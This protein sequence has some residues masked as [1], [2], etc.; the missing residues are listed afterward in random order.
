MAEST[1]FKKLNYKDRPAMLA[2]MRVSRSAYCLWSF[3]YLR[4]EWQ[5]ASKLNIFCVAEKFIVRDTGLSKNVVRE[6]KALLIAHG[7]ITHIG[8]RAMTGCWDTNEYLVQVGTAPTVAQKSGA[9][10]KADHRSPKS[11][12]PTGARKVGSTVDV[13]TSGTPLG[14]GESSGG[15]ESRAGGC[16]GSPPTGLGF[17]RSEG[18]GGDRHARDANADALPSRSIDR[19]LENQKRK[20]NPMGAAPPN[21][22]CGDM[23]VSGFKDEEFDSIPDALNPDPVSE[24][25]PEPELDD[26]PEFTEA[27][28]LATY[29]WFFLLGRKSLGEKITIL[30]KWEQYWSTD[31][32]SLLDQ[33]A[34]R[35]DIELA[36][37]VSQ[38]PASREFY[39]RSKSIVDQF[40]LLTEKGQSLENQKQDHQCAYC[41]S[42]F[43]LGSEL[44][45]HAEV[46]TE[47]PG[48][49]P[50]DIAEEEAMYAAEDPDPYMQGAV[51]DPDPGF[52]PF[53]DS[54]FAELYDDEGNTVFK[55][56]DDDSQ[57][58][59]PI[60]IPEDWGQHDLNY[61]LPE[62]FKEPARGRIRPEDNYLSPYISDEKRISPYRECGDMAR[63]DGEN[64]KGGEE[65]PSQDFGS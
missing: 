20:P 50:E 37:W 21:P 13:F 1:G 25:E 8:G 17:E 53:A 19:D 51:S 42:F 54:R 31:F 24:P 33:G 18:F 15:V 9:G 26:I 34:T 4:A 10:K 6:A 63:S 56:T 11:G 3:M 58:W 65:P 35:A 60:L 28:C 38:L 32:Q 29:L 47:D 40:W 45:A 30:P 57:D 39:I 12:L 49:D 52:D 41:Y 7:W 62:P 55:E 22:P 36:I 5:E 27:R 23:G 48:A 59:Q 43:S 14:A 44:R 16:G 64:G 2:L 61:E 46:C